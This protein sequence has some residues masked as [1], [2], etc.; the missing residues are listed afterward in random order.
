MHRNIH[1][2]VSELCTFAPN[3]PDDFRASYWKDPLIFVSSN[4]EEKGGSL[5]A[6]MLD[7]LGQY[8]V[9][10]TCRVLLRLIQPSKPEMLSL[11]SCMKNMPSRSHVLP[12]LEE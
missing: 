4:A 10:N 6:R 1:D 11:A 7:S 12:R 3:S 5:V 9:V 8:H 2:W